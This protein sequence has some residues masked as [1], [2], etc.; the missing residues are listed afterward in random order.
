MEKRSPKLREFHLS[1]S[2]DLFARQTESSFAKHGDQRRYHVLSQ[3]A[4]I[5]KRKATTD[6]PKEDRKVC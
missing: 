1:H 2:S 3:I 4:P 5:T 6:L